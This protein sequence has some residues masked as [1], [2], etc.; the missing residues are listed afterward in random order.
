M[1][2]K[3][4]VTFSCIAWCKSSLLCIRHSSGFPYGTGSEHVPPM[5]SGLDSI[6]NAVKPADRQQRYASSLHERELRA[7][8]QGQLGICKT[9]PVSAAALHLLDRCPSGCCMLGNVSVIVS[10]LR[11]LTSPWDKFWISLL[12]SG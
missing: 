9:R 6:H 3:V 1:F 5:C 7:P 4:R 10:V 11:I 2:Y 8:S 12:S